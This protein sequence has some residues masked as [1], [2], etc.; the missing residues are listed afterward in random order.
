MVFQ[1]EVTQI[2]RYI[3]I[4]DSGFTI[5]DAANPQSDR[6]IQGINAPGATS[7]SS[8]VLL[9]RTMCF[10]KPTFS[11]R[12]NSDF[13]LQLTPSTPGPHAWHEVV[14][15]P[16]QT[17]NELTFAVSGQGQIT[18][19]DIVILYTSSQVTVKVP[20]VLEQ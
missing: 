9:F 1:Q 19:S 13:T 5:P 12:L 8:S 3:T 6:H 2:A 11:V 7:G 17:G 4:A 18:F 14:S 20:P 10:G 15:S 16:K